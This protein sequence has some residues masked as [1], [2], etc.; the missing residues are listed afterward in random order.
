M[1]WLLFFVA[2]F[3][4]SLGIFTAVLFQSNSDLKS[5]DQAK[6]GIDHRTHYI[7]I[8]QD[9]KDALWKEIE[10]G[11]EQAANTW[12]AVVEYVEPEY[13]DM[14]GELK[15]LSKS[16]AT[17]ADGI[18]INGFNDERFKGLIDKASESGISVITINNDT[19]KSERAAYIGPDNYH[20]GQMCAQRASNQKFIS[21]KS[22]VAIVTDSIEPIDK[23]MIIL[24]FRDYLN[25]QKQTTIKTVATSMSVLDVM[26]KTQNLLAA[27]PEVNLLYCTNATATLGVVRA[28]LDINKVNQVRIIGVGNTPEIIHYVKAGVIDSTID[29][30]PIEIGKLAIDNM[31]NQKQGKNIPRESITDFSLI[32]AKSLTVAN[33]K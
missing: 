30:K 25:G 1:K 10:R 28:V 14:D 4:V 5:V 16:I 7:L 15:L 12:G 9:R 27:Y 31:C 22:T 6:N 20:I 11:V 19:L 33:S 8:E 13:I 23:N 17:K 26:D 21:N 2:V 3:L 29:I 24:G 18:I 32:D